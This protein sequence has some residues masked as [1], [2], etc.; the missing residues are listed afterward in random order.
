MLLMDHLGMSPMGDHLEFTI[1]Q[2][3]ED[4]FD[5]LDVAEPYVCIHPGSRGRWRQWPPDLFA[6]IADECVEAGYNVVITGVTS[7]QDITN[8]VKKSMRYPAIDLTG[9]TT[10]GSMAV[11]LRNSRLL[12]SNC[13]GVSHIA[14]ATQ[15]PSVVLS[16][17]GEPERWAP[18]NRKL[19]RTINCASE[20]RL[21]DVLT[22][23]RSQLSLSTGKKHEKVDPWPGALSTTTR[24]L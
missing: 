10:L 13:T 7:E 19:H 15:T 8:S 24:P 9:M 16:M 6:I 5:L 23:V 20:N 21:E 2:D 17:D 12:V 3:D 14:A 1:T 11:L 18:L 4:N 22:S